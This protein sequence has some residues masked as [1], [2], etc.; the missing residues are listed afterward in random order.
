MLQLSGIGDRAFLEGLG[1]DVHLD[2]PGVGRNLQEQTNTALGVFGNNFETGG[3]GP[4][5]VRPGPST[6]DW[7]SVD[8]SERTGHRVPEH[9][10]AV[11]RERECEGGRDGSEPGSVGGKSGA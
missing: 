9:L 7:H 6:A 11:R 1:I 2:L 8:A 10:R 3:V 5:T 4:N